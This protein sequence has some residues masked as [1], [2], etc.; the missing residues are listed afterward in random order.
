[1]M[2]NELN[3]WIDNP[4][5]LN[6]ET[7]LKLRE[8]MAKY[9]Y[10][11]TVRLL[12]TQNLAILQNPLLPKALQQAALFIPDRKVLFKIIEGERFHITPLPK[13]DE[14]VED[15]ELD[16]TSSLIDSFL[17]GYKEENQRE[18]IIPVELNMDY[19]PLLGEVDGED[20]QPTFEMKG[21]HL[22][23][24]FIAADESDGVFVDG[25]PSAT[26]GVN[27]GDMLTKTERSEELQR[28]KSDME[29][30]SCLTETLA[31][32]YVKQERYAKA[33]EI[34]KKLNL[35]YPEKNSYFADQIRFLEKLII[36]TKSK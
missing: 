13:H 33:L 4:Q 29:E 2:L 12:Y 3:E 19:A 30:E 10:C 34:I 31:K 36:N 35:K 1:M 8:W 9:P 24:S 18:V 16:R 17:L 14:L 21:Q 26:V 11:Q 28:A 6:V 20:V 22:I 27:R 7:L 32:I 15:G 25:L 5:L 23:D